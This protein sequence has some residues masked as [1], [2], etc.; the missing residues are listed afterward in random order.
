MEAKTD[1]KAAIRQ[2][3]ERKTP[4]GAFA[5]RTAGGG[6][7]WVQ[8]SRNLDAARNGL[9]FELN[10]GSHRNH[11]LQAEWNARGEAAFEFEVLEVLP[12]DLLDMELNDRLKEVKTRWAE[13]LGARPV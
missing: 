9:W 1:R 7:V 2:Y 11:E 10:H 6:P 13:R 3:K 8:A 4:R 12:D 5:V